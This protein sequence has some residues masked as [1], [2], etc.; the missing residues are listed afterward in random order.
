MKQ[1][2]QLLFDALRLSRVNNLLIVALTQ[3]FSALFLFNEWAVWDLRFFIL[4]L[5]TAMITASGYYINDYYDVKIDLINKPDKVIVGK[6]IKRRQVMAAHLVFNGIGVI[7]GTLVSWRIGLV[8]VAVVILLWYYSNTLKRLPFVGNLTVATLTAASILVLNIYFGQHHLL[9]Y[10]YAFFAFG[11]NLIREIIKDLE[12]IKGDHSFGSMSLPI[13]LGLRPTKYI[14]YM[15]IILFVMALF[16]FLERIDKPLLSIY[17]LVLLGPFIYFT[18][19]VYRAD[20]K[21][22]YTVLSKYCKWFILAGIFSMVVL[23]A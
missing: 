6:K 18:L 12:D 20:T 4:V 22:H 3:Y 9:V 8:D 14:I 7:L 5:S 21:K 13:W 15:L 19:L 17:F 16:L 23:R 2:L 11:I 10:T 1:Y